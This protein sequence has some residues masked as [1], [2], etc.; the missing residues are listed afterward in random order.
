MFFPRKDSFTLTC[1]THLGSLNKIRIGHDNTGFGAAWFL[2]KASC[3]D[4]PIVLGSLF[5]T[6]YPSI[7]CVIIYSPYHCTFQVTVEDPKTGETVEFP[8]QRWFSTSE[9]DGQ[10][11]RELTRTGKTCGVECL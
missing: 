10:I 8:C 6:K 7:I 3:L 2:D 9:D 4:I 5:L 11:T 1:A